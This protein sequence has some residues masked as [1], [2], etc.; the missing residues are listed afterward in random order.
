M[1][2]EAFNPRKPIIEQ[3]T[4]QEVEICEHLLEGVPHRQAYAYV[5]YPEAKRDRRMITA[6]YKSKMN[7]SRMQG[8]FKRT[9]VREYLRHRNEQIAAKH[10]VTRDWWLHKLR[11][12]VDRCLQAEPALDKDGN[13]TGVY[14]FDSSGAARALD[15]IGKYLGAYE[16]HNAQQTVGVMKE[17]K[18]ALQ[19]V[20][21]EPKAGPENAAKILDTGSKAPRT[22]LH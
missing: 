3:M 16:Q 5:M 14:K 8:L 1:K 21:A 6:W 18:R 4:L 7:R 12:L 15:Q 11:T 13:P 19:E 2:R 17:I 22:N 9:V 10:E 20:W